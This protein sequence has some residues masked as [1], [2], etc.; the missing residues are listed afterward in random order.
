MFGKSYQVLKQQEYSSGEYKLVPIRSEDRYNIMRW[1][2]EQIFHLRQD[3]ELTIEEQDT[4]FENIVAKLFDQAQP[5]Q[6]LFS[7]LK[8]KECIG[9]G[10]LVHID[11][12]HKRAEISF[13]M[14]TEN[15][16]LFFI[17][18]WNH[19]LKMIE[20]VAFF[21]LDFHKIY[22]Y[23]YNIRPRLYEVLSLRK[24]IKEG[25]LKDH[26]CI[27]NKYI[28]VMF[29]SK[30]NILHQLTLEQALKEDSK[31]LF[32]WRNE[33]STRK[34]S[35][36]TSKIDWS[37]HSNWF[38]QKLSSDESVIF[39]LKAKEIKIG[40]IRLDYS[41]G[42]WE[43]NYSIDQKYR[44]KGY[45]MAIVK[46]CMNKSF[47]KNYK[48]TVKMDNVISQ[49]VFERLNFT[50]VQNENKYIYTYTKR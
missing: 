30:F 8:D 7:F 5:K 26:I 19:F 11:W 16:S 13:V 50:K 46:M 23:S 6:I 48:A 20:H 10:G 31:I 49:K 4:Y 34:Q 40:Q 44:G 12:Q 35:F 45:G 42:F 3:K 38:N 43:I 24:F 15:E 18:Y 47:N 14:K 39:I 22:T 25:E 37:E 32:N 17:E 36:K 28:E 1:R 33:F 21:A 27:E 29:H 9:Y 2:N 41:E